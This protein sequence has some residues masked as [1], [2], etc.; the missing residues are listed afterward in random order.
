MT[1]SA[2]ET[3]SPWNGRAADSSDVEA[4]GDLASAL[5][6]EPISG[7]SVVHDC[8]RFRISTPM[9]HGNVVSL[10][11]SLDD[12]AGQP[13]VSFVEQVEVDAEVD[14]TDDR[15]LAVLEVLALCAGT[16]YYKVAAPPIVHVDMAIRPAAAA[17][18]EHLYDHGLREFAV[19]N[20]LPVPLDVGFEW[21]A[22]PSMAD[23][24]AAERP[25][26][27]DRRALV[28]VGGGKDS[29]LVMS[30]FGDAQP[31]AIG[32]PV[33]SVRVA[34]AAHRDLLTAR[35]RIDQQLRGL[36]ETGALNG[37]IPVTAITSAVSVLVAL[38]GGFDDVLLGN[39]RSA[40]EPTRWVGPE[41]VNHQYSK[42]IAFEKVFAAAI[43]EATRGAVRYFSVLRPFSELAIARGLS[44]DDAMLDGFLSCNNAFTLW[45][46]TEQSKHA[47]WC[48][49]CPKCRFTALMIAPF[50]T[51]E[52]VAGILG[53]DIFDDASQI[54]GFM[55][56]WDEAAKPFECVGEM[57]ESAVAMTMLADDPGWAST[58]VVASTGPSARAYAASRHGSAADVLASGDEHFIPEP[59]WGRIRNRLA[60][61]GGDV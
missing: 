7:L 51:R 44:A 9:I 3:N 19:N 34:A 1:T 56:L 32:P 36:N 14:P 61:Q 28:P 47:T 57:V 6:A 26:S 53:G 29:A 21:S 59:Y 37:H 31:F 30:V 40:S 41:P 46:E 17:L 10:H 27:P 33:P 45:R 49:N 38:V 5:D 2:P 16:S 4:G 60:P 54:E 39:E 25:K 55:E 15:V 23:G 43:S 35:R 8:R 24:Q 18:L 13:L 12:Q 20:G 11:Y 58:A 50:L 22:L 48:R 42:S 52:R